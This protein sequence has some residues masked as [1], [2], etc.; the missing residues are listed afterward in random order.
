MRDACSWIVFSSPVYHDDKFLP[1]P[2]NDTSRLSVIP[3]PCFKLPCSPTHIALVSSVPLHLFSLTHISILTTLFCIT[4]SPHHS[5]PPT[6]LYPHLTTPCTVSSPHLPPNHH[7]L[8][9][10]HHTPTSLP[11][12][13]CIISSPRPTYLSLLSSQMSPIL[14]TFS[15]IMIPHLHTPMM[16][17]VYI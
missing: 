12:I 11:H 2:C 16:Y 14:I 17:Y 9:P 3:C 1:L 8:P 6:L 4:P 10:P 13:R 15:S 5:L 7:T